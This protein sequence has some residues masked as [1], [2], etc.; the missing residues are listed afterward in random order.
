M[1][2]PRTR[3][4]TPLA[5]TRSDAKRKNTTLAPYRIGQAIGVKR[6]RANT[7]LPR[8]WRT[9]SASLATRRTPLGHPVY[10]SRPLLGRPPPT[11]NPVGFFAL[12]VPITRGL[13]RIRLQPR[14]TT[15]RAWTS[16]T[17]RPDSRQLQMFRRHPRPVTE[18][19]AGRLTH[20]AAIT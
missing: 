15:G 12:A 10:S 2:H 13:R 4:L 18:S 5:S 7:G 1:I 19:Q 17:S 8:W 14:S 6:K 3:L 16:S 9:N 11:P 20:L